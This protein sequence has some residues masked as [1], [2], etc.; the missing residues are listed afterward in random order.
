MKFIFMPEDITHQY[1]PS[2]FQIFSNLQSNFRWYLF[3]VR[4]CRNSC[5]KMFGDHLLYSFLIIFVLVFIQKKMVGTLFYNRTNHLL[6]IFLTNP[7][8]GFL[9]VVNNK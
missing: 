3:H 6:L 2:I 9:H 5:K 8:Q 7:V 1:H 4:A